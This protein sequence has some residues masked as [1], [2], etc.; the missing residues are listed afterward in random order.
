[1]SARKDTLSQKFDRHRDALRF[2]LDHIRMNTQ[3][4]ESLA[5]T[6]NKKHD[7]IESLMR[8]ITLFVQVSND[9]QDDIKMHSYKINDMLLDIERELNKIRE[10]IEPQ[11]TKKMLRITD[12][13]SSSNREPVVQDIKQQKK[14]G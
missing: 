13:D 3:N 12:G 2:C 1:M 6:N 9:H 14:V 10:N 5:E 7:D 8:N 11:S 4:S